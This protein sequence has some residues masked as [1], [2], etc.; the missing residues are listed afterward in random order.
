M[1]HHI[2]ASFFL[3]LLTLVLTSCGFS[4]LLHGFQD[5]TSQLRKIE[6]MQKL[7][8]FYSKFAKHNMKVKVI[9]FSAG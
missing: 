1:M 8:M 5:S 6:L 7:F 2:K 4:Q 9:K 3:L